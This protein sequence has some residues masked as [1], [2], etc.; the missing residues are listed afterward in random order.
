M[1]AVIVR[2]INERFEWGHSDCSFVFDVVEAMTGFDAIEDLRGYE[3][4]LGAILALKRAGFDTV[5]ELVELC[6]NEIHPG[7]AGRGDLGYPE[8]IAH[9][10]MSPAIIDGAHCF[11]KQPAGGIVVPRAAIVRAW[12][13]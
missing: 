6:F 11:S 2:H 8:T 4:E 3:S 12:A 5:R 9:P 10:L 7:M 13:V 1:R